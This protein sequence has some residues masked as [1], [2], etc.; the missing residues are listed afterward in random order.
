MKYLFM[1]AQSGAIVEC[2]NDLTAILKAARLF[3]LERIV[4]LDDGTE[5]WANSSRAA[6][7]GGDNP[8]H[9]LMNTLSG[10]AC[11]TCRR[12]TACQ[13]GKRRGFVDLVS[14]TTSLSLDIQLQRLSKNKAASHIGLLDRRIRSQ[15]RAPCEAIPEPA[16]AWAG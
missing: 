9:P 15:L 8:I 7:P 12:F 10:H 13:E 11:F 6:A 16:L 3:D 2:G 14:E 1:S 5:V 4:R